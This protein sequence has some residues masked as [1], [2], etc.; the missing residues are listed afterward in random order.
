MANEVR[1]PRGIREYR[2]LLFPA[3]CSFTPAPVLALAPLASR[4]SVLNSNSDASDKIAGLWWFMLIASLFALAVV[5]LLLLL[6]ILRGRGRVERTSRWLGRPGLVA[7]AGVGVPFVILVVLFGLTLETMGSTSPTNLN[8]R[9]TIDVTGHQ[10]FW[11]VRYP[12]ARAATA[13]EIHIPVGVPVAIK[14]RTADVA[15]SFWAPGLNRKL[16]AIPGR[17]NELHIKA[18]KPG[19]FRGQCAEFCGAQHANMAFL[20]VA[21]EPAA[22][23]SWLDGQSAPVRYR[24]NI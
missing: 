9:M 3:A 23:Q 20:V 16:D 6:A 19:T 18:N 15:H 8:P 10:F 14:L 13:N 7:I 17:V 21:D 12:Q 22:F 5:L 24:F 11:E 4:Q 1:R 2:R